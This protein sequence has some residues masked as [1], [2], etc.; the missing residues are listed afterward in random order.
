M[1]FQ[2][3]AERAYRNIAYLVIAGSAVMGLPLWD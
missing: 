2:P 1:L 3:N